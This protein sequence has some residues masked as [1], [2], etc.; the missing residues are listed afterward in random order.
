LPKPKIAVGAGNVF[1]KLPVT[2]NVNENYSS[3]KYEAQWKATG[4]KCG[5]VPEMPPPPIYV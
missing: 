1:N 3:T 2:S 4:F 5:E